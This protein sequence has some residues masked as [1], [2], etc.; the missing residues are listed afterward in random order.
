LQ[1]GARHYERTTSRVAHRN[2]YRTRYGALELL[3]AV[4][5]KPF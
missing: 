4:W 1:V 2:G 3:K 5:D